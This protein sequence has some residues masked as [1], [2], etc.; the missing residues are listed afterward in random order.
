[1]KV[2]IL[3]LILLMCIFGSCASKYR[4]INPQSL[5]YTKGA[6]NEKID[7]E[8]RYDLLN[9]KYAKKEGKSSIRLVSVKLT[10]NTD[11]NLTFGQDFNLK[12][13]SG[14][15]INPVPLNSVYNEIKQGEAIYFLYLLLTFTRLN[16][17]ETNS[18]GGYT[19]VKTKSYPIGLAIGPGIALGNFFGARGANK[20]F[21]KDLMTYD[22]NYKSIK[23]G[24]T[25]YGLVGIY[26]NQYEG[27]EVNFK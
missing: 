15:D 23:P 27:L 4:K 25:I 16:I 12:T 9:K 24:E 19:E 10:N 2:K 21:K 3:S 22:L 13:T 11:E 26:A 17:S 5:T 6:S 14:R 20:N 18:S 1:M 7:F 8:Y